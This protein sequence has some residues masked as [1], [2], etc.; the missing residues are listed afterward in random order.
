MQRLHLEKE[1]LEKNEKL[2]PELDLNTL[3]DYMTLRKKR[4]N[5][6]KAK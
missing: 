4:I 2:P 3:P 5:E 6:K 1:M